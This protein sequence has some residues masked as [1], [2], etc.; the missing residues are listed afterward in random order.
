MI[1]VGDVEEGEVGLRVLTREPEILKGSALEVAGPGGLPEK[2][3]DFMGSLVV[4]G[5]KATEDVAVF[6]DDNNTG[7]GTQ[8]ELPPPI[9]LRVVKTILHAQAGGRSKVLD[10]FGVGLA[11]QNAHPGKPRAVFH[12]QFRHETTQ[13]I[14]GTVMDVREEDHHGTAVKSI[15][16]ASLTPGERAE[17]G[18]LGK[19]IGI[20]GRTLSTS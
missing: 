7:K 15:F 3:S 19:V 2:G 14:V 16:Q 5:V 17:K 8:A 6:V 9:A 12:L 10:F 18:V 4:E 11:D 1:P 13:R 20:D